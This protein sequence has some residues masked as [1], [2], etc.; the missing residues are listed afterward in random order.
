VT[1]SGWCSGSGSWN[2]NRSWVWCRNRSWRWFD[3]WRRLRVRRDIRLFGDQDG[4]S[5]D[6]LEVVVEQI[7]VCPASKLV[8]HGAEELIICVFPKR[9]SISK[10]I[11]AK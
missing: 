4:L 11:E 2:L 5:L 1:L 8:V 6:G 10:I 7:V 3:S 9:K